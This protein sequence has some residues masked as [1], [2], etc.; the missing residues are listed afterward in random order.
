L[1]IDLTVNEGD[2]LCLNKPQHFT[3]S[4]TFM[5]LQTSSKTNS[6][7]FTHKDHFEIH[8]LCCN[9]YKFCQFTDKNTFL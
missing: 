3:Y 7:Q 1:Y 8:G 2:P 4:G 9:W 5:E 6:V